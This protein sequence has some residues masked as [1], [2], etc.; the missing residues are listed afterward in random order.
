MSVCAEA[1][2]CEERA[3]RAHVVPGSRAERQG[4][5]TGVD[6]RVASDEAKPLSRDKIEDQFGVQGDDRDR[7]DG[8]NN[9]QPPGRD[10][11]PHFPAVGRELNQ[12]HNRERQLQAED[13]LRQDQQLRGFSLAIEQ[14]DAGGGN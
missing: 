6:F 11:I 4:L 5:A 7:D 9:C 10:E 13:D 14:R 1:T 2:T 8:C 12:R 3:G